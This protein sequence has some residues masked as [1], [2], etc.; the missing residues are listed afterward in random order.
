M[1]VAMVTGSATK[2]GVGFTKH[3]KALFVISPY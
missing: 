3:A 1:P 2:A